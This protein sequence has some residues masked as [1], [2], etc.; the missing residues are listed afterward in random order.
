MYQAAGRRVQGSHVATLDP[1]RRELGPDYQDHAVQT[2]TT[3][4]EH[5]AAGGPIRGPP[6]TPVLRIK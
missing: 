6:A 1:E 5:P 4:L 2:I 3:L